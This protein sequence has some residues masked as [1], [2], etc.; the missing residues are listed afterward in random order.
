[1]LLSRFPEPHGVVSLISLH[2]ASS[3]MLMGELE[4]EGTLQAVDQSSLPG[5][6]RGCTFVFGKFRALH[7][8]RFATDLTSREWGRVH[9]V[10]D[11]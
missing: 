1:M 11:R 6:C 3:G 4:E 7:P 2:F 5:V 10:G 9:I 8:L